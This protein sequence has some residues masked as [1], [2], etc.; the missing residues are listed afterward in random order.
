MH[1][2]CNQMSDLFRARLPPMLC[3]GCAHRSA[4][5]EA[6]T[7]WERYMATTSA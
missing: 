6:K 1:Q 5:G 2:P 7:R 3:S 4:R